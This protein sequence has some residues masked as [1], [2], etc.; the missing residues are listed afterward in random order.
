VILRSC[1]VGDHES[2]SGQKTLSTYGITTCSCSCHDDGG[3]HV[4]QPIA[5]NPPLDVL[6]AETDL[7][8]TSV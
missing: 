5:P 1:V 6:Y 8:L 2:C 7:V 4:R 3:S